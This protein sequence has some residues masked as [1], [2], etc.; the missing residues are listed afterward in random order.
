M[1]DSTQHRIA[2]ELEPDPSHGPRSDE[3]ESSQYWKSTSGY[4]YR[5]MIRNRQE[6][7]SRG[8]A[9]QEQLLT[10]LML[11]EQRALSRPLDVLEFGCGFGRHAAYLSSLEGVR[12]H[13]YD[14]S[15]AMMEPLR[16]A[17]PVGLQPVEERL[18]SG[19]DALT[20]VGSR[21]FD[22][23]FTVSVLIHNP[24]ERLP[25]LLDTLGKLVRPGG[26]LCLVENK[27]VPVGVWDN[28]WHDGCWLHPYA[29]LVPT[30]WDLHYGSGLMETHDLYVFKRHEGQ[31]R[32]YFLLS[33]AERAREETREVTL[34]SLQ[35]QSLPRLREWTLQA[36]EALRG[37]GR[38]GDMRVSELKERL[39]V[40]LQRSAR[41]Q[42]LLALSDELA[43]LRSES[44]EAPRPAASSAPTSPGHVVVTEGVVVDAPLDTR[45][46]H[47]EPRLARL[48]HI[49]HQEWYGIRAASGYA[50]G[51]KI[52][53][54]ASRPLTAADHRR[55]VET[56][57]A[58]GARAVVFQG[59][60]PNAL[61]VVHMLRRV[62]GGALKLSC[63]W[64]GSTSQFHFDIELN[65]FSRLLALKAE[66]VLDGVA[67][68]KP[69]MHQLSPH[70]YPDVLLNF[71]PRV[72]P[73][74]CRHRAPATRAALVPTPNNWWKNFYSNV[75]VAA[76]L[77]RIDR[78]FVTSAFASS[79]EIP[80]RASIVNV[81]PL[82]RAELFH[83]IRE[84]DVLLNV[85]LSECQPMTALEGMAHGVACLT[86]PISLG[87][88]DEHP[89]QKMVQIAG[90]GALGDIRSAVSRVLELRDRAPDEYAQMLEDYTRILCADAVNR[91]LEFAQP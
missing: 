81:G 7:G 31:R 1:R 27:L 76:S 68:V 62:F 26:L 8:Y 55:I 59:F 28:G 29:E 51:H 84:S 57:E 11:T 46:A 6:H 50:P 73:E 25:G 63:V 22:I 70:I 88:L 80:L 90:T 52:G 18:W 5:E 56:C 54:T 9:Q 37:A 24:P 42:R 14:F 87:R 3:P 43:Q 53:I 16:S 2:P 49:F 78:V 74:D 72:A 35:V 71:P 13:G 86:G 39:D 58:L 60:S 48:V 15:E 44:L 4:T 77:P 21:Q 85:S 64:H 79:P 69:Q 75:S 82:G 47:P 67:C 30:G 32:R 23:V 40:E 89:F 45:W 38:T 66:G 19:P 61:E 34:E 36:G 83:L 65:S 12:Y 33:A 17:P 91:Y 20:A 10:T 41:R